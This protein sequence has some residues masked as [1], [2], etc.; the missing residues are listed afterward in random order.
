M[1]H[2]EV[3]HGHVRTRLGRQTHRLD[4]I[5]RF[6]DDLEPL[7]LQQKSESLPYDRMVIR[8]QDTRRHTGECSGGGARANQGN[9]RIRPR[10][11]PA[12][13]PGATA[14]AGEPVRAGSV[15]G[16]RRTGRARRSGG[17]RLLHDP[18]PVGFGGLE[19]DPEKPGDFLRR[20]PLGDQLQDLALAGG[21]RIAG[22]P[23]WPGR[24]RPPRARCRG[25]GTSCPAAPR[26]SPAP[27]PPRPG[28]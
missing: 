17:C 2:G 14:Q 19:A 1:R 13:R 8:Q 5:G 16:E 24:P 20:L 23:T 28:S 15:R 3:E 12:G 11:T 18:R 10:E 21:Q 4:A 9:A 27:D 6:G 25:S 7:P 22:S 26:G